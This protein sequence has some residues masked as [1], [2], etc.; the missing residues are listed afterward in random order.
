MN[1]WK[2]E[3]AR[4]STPRQL[5]KVAR[6]HLATLTPQDLASV[7]EPCRPTRI[8]GLDDLHHW[9]ER[10]AEEFCSG[11]ART[12]QS[13]AHRELIAF[14]AAARDRATALAG[15]TMSSGASAANDDHGGEPRESRS[16]SATTGVRDE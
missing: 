10:L 6:E 3:V 12:P 13:A 1:E 14:F 4:A 5:L 15:A 16:R 9:H 2:E 7:P 8:K 11:A